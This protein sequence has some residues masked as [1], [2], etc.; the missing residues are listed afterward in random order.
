MIIKIHET[1]FFVDLEDNETSRAFCD[2]LSMKLSMQD[3]NGNEKYAYL[4]SP[5]PTKPIRIQTIHAGDIM[6]WQDRCIVVF[7]KTFSTKYAYTKIGSIT[8]SYP[9]QQCLGTKN[10]VVQFLK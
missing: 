9:L 10:V 2:L 5:L 1:T 6:L 3:L 7:Y 4:D 8:N